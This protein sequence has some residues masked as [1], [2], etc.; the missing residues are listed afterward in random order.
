MRFVGAESVGAQV[1]EAR[2][3]TV[4]CSTSTP[5]PG[6]FQDEPADATGYP[7]R[8]FCPVLRAVVLLVAIRSHRRILIYWLVPV[9]AGVLSRARRVAARQNASS[10]A[11]ISSMMGTMS[12]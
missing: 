10:P 1:Q 6:P 4:G 8:M 7:L 9:L 12:G 5:T 2:S 3:F 11:V